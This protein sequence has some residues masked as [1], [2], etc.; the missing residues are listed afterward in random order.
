MARLTEA[1]LVDLVRAHAAAVLGH[2]EAGTVS[3]D[4]AFRELGFDSLTAVELR[5]R[6]NAAT[7]LRLPATVTFDHPNATALAVHIRGRLTGAKRSTP[8]QQA[9]ADEPIAI[10]GMACRFPGGVKTPEQLWDLVIGEVDAMSDFPTDRGW[11]VDALPGPDASSAEHAPVGGFLYDAAD[12]DPGFFGVSPREATAM[13]PQQRLLLE[14]SWE[15]LERAGIAPHSLR[16]SQTG[17]FAGLMYHDYGKSG[18]DDPYLVTGNTGSV[19]SGRVAYALGLEG[20]AVTV[21]TAC[22]SS[23]VALHLACQALRQGDC[24]LALAGGATVMSTPEMLVEFSRQGG[25]AADGRCKAFAGAA[26]GTGFSEGVGMVLVERLSD[27]RRN[28]HQVLAV[29]R[30]S[31]VNQDGASNGLTAPNGP[32]QER[33][34]RQ[35]LANAQVSTV[36]VDV[37]EAHGTGTTLGDPIEAQALLATYGQDRERPLLLGTVKSNIGHTQA[38]AGMA[39]VLKMV[40]GMYHGV[41]PRTLHV[42]VPSEHVPWESGAVSLV[43]EA[44]PWPESGRPRRAGVSSFGVSGTNAHVIL[45][46]PPVDNQDLVDNPGK[47]DLEPPKLSDPPISMETGGPR[48]E[49]VVPWIIS[50]RSPAALKAQAERLLTVASSGLRPLDVGWSLATSRS[51][52]EHRAVVLGRDSDEFRRAL[53]A[54]PEGKQ[55][56]GGK[57]AFL[58]SGQGSQRLGMGRELCDRFE[59]FARSFDET[60]GHLD[61]PLRDVLFGADPAKLDQT[62]YTQAGLFAVEVALFRLL[63]HWG[64]RPDFLL[65]HS[66]GEL[67]A[68]HVAGVLNLADACRL[69]AARGR[70]MQDLPAGGAM[71]AV[72]AAENEVTLTDGVVIA[73]V[74]GPA[75]V[76]LSGDEAAVSELAATFAE[77]GRRIKQLRV[78]HAFHSP[79]MRPMLAEFARVAAGLTY[80][81]PRLPVISNLTGSADE[82]MSR[83]EYWVQQVRQPVRF[84]DGVNALAAAGVRRFVELGPSGALTSMVRDCLPDAAAIPSMRRDRSEE[85]TVLDAVTQLHVLGGRVDLP[86]LFDGRPRR[87][88]L[89]TYAFQRDRYWLDARTPVDASSLGLESTGHPLLGAALDLP[90]GVLLT[91]RLSTRDHPW[92]ADHAVLGTTVAPGTLLVELAIHAGE[93]V[94]C[95][96]LAELTMQAPLVLPAAVHVSV[97]APDEQGNRPVDILSRNG[98]RHATGTLS[99]AS[100]NVPDFPRTWPPARAETLNIDYAAMPGLEYGPAFQGVQAVWRLNDQ[101]F[102]DVELPAGMSAE[103]YAVHPALLDAALHPL[104]HAFAPDSGQVWVPFAWSDVSVYANGAQAVR[105]QLTMAGEKVSVVLADENGQPVASVG[106]LSG[107]PVSAGQLGG[108]RHGTLH[109]IDWVPFTGAVASAPSHIAQATEI[110]PDDPAPEVVVLPVDDQDV[111]QATHRVLAA[112]Q[113]WLADERFA[114]ARLA[115]VTR[116]VS[117]GMNLAG[118]AVWGLIR[119]AQA[120]HP[121]R[122]MLLDLDQE[123]G[124]PA[125]LTC[126][127]PQVAVRNGTLLVPKLVRRQVTAGQPEFGD[128][129]VLI[130]G[131]NGA[132]GRLVARHLVETHNVRELLLVSRSGVDAELVDDLTAS[133][134]EVATAACDV[135]D[136]A[137]LA[138]LITDRI[139]ARI[140]AVVHTAGVIEDGTLESL[141]PHRMDAVLAP[142]VDAALNL[143]ELTSDLS[144]FVL[145]S[146]AAGVIGTPGQASYAAANAFLDALAVHRHALGLPATSVAWGPWESS[147]MAAKLTDRDLKRMARTGVRPLS[148]EEGL[149]MFDAAVGSGLPTVVAARMETA[150]AKVRRK[151][152]RPGSSL[153]DRLAKVSADERGPILLDLVRTNAATV[154]GYDSGERI[155]AGQA[156]QDLGFDSLTA[157]E[158]RNLLDSATGLNLPATVVF[159]YPNPA[160]LTEYLGDRLGSDD[161]TSMPALLRELD[162]LDVV[163]ASV[164]ADESAR[165]GLAGRLRSLVSRLAGGAGRG[166][167][168]TASDEEIFDLLDK[169]FGIS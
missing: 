169:D 33:V 101:V 58:F 40:L 110:G 156:F 41:V 116:G 78:S 34:I 157:V 87:V 145:F 57:T 142:K 149:A 106:G 26:D 47:G 164:T 39:G 82:D 107:R 1:E 55:D 122:F 56:L 50:A 83:P 80:N 104:L 143:H 151:A 89:P 43:T 16:G 150:P 74:N 86:A 21:D 162:R 103:D 160:A 75:S 46:Q 88:D 96:H 166:T 168:E 76:V 54:L 29:V 85:L 137:A 4:R 167:F 114:A 3:A 24:T 113:Q 99:A 165:A 146:S 130:T 35:A 6:L 67:A 139:T 105:V 159:D 42:D 129:T 124:L 7:G 38:A 44:V 48:P 64:A 123:S 125:A 52:L 147:G 163:L 15:V 5:N 94:G 128:G 66:I 8:I 117:D 144:A 30:G 134:A 28:G 111:H 148:A 84:A 138:A 9:P 120:E 97:G 93:R 17:V 102:A 63:E 72:H 53:T 14:V 45:E 91:G 140:T 2:S 61:L 115:V 141:T 62:L 31:A 13:D 109:G 132:L 127:E 133:G 32:S 49:Q 36:D 126:N 92:L 22:S 119:S 77:Q 154:L 60:C 65:G 90:N 10:V 37:V 59:P 70:L 135:S 73:A 11:T 136:R 71:I 158:F 100:E 131:A 112:T 27:A 79:R 12:F 155:E 19:A 95:A 98:V 121:G 23:L 161:A 108:A 18:S 118:A 69:V 51:T 153:A 81:A 25:L 20:P 68:A 152:N